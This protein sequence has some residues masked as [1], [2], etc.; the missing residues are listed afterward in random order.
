MKELKRKLTHILIRLT[1]GGLAAIKQYNTA[2]NLR[3]SPV[4]YYISYPIGIL[5]KILV[6]FVYKE[7]R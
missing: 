7:S 2:K 5:L 1:I 4:S 3:L 6:H